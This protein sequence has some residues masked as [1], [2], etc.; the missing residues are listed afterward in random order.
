MGPHMARIW[1][2]AIAIALRFER[3]GAHAPEHR[4][5]TG[6]RLVC[7]LGH[8]IRLL[9]DTGDSRLRGASGERVPHRHHP[10]A[11]RPSDRARTRGQKGWSRWTLWR[12]LS[13]ARGP[14]FH[15]GRR[16][17]VDAKRGGERRHMPSRA[18]CARGPAAEVPESEPKIGHNGW[19]G[20]GAHLGGPPAETA[21]KR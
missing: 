9:P 11:L 13:R 15:D 10:L 1:P 6:C 5:S 16:L 21:R 4:R 20:V 17:E 8:G 2:A 14:Q 12:S 19:R 18:G 3:S 7:H